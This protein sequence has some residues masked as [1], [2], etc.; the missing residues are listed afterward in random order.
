MSSPIRKTRS[1]RRI[2]SRRPSEMA[3]RYV[4]VANGVPSLVVGGVE[5]FRLGVD[6]FERRRRV[7]ERALLGPLRGLV[8]EALHLDVDLVLEALVEDAVL[9]E[10]ATVALDR[11][12]A[13]VVL[14]ELARDVEGVVVDGVPLHPQRDELEQRR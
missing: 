3:C 5:L 14:E 9:L 10:P 13:A 1:S 2:S 11:V 8:Q 6:A 12:L 4:F 7:G